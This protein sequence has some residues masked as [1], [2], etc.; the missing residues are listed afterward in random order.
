[1]IADALLQLRILQ[2]NQRGKLY[3]L[4]TGLSPPGPCHARARFCIYAKWTREIFQGREAF[5][6]E[7]DDVLILHAGQH[8]FGVRDCL[9][10]T[11]TIYFHIGAGHKDTFQCGKETP[12]EGALLPPLIHCGGR[13]RIKLLFQELVSIWHEPA[14]RRDR[15]LDTLFELLLLELEEC[16]G[17]E[18]HF[19][20]EILLRSVSCWPKIHRSSLPRGAFGSAWHLRQDAEPAFSAPIWKNLLSIPDGRKNAYGPAVPPGLS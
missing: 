9:P 3:L 16:C 10:G 17:Q 20:D 12:S 5:F 8:H 6:M 15:K 18:A 4:C 13:P 14:P 7:N 1:M 2:E 19:H 11:Q